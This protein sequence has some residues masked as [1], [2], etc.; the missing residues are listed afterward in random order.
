MS[1]PRF[2]FVDEDVEGDRLYLKGEE[3]H[4]AVR[5]A[6]VRV[7]ERIEAINGR[8]RCLKGR[9]VEIK[10][11]YVA[12]A[13]EEERFEE[14]PGVKICLGFGLL[15]GDKNEQVIQ[16]GTELGVWKFLVFEGKRSVARLK[17]EGRRLER[18]RRVAIEACK[19]S[20]RAWVPEIEI[21]GFEGIVERRGEGL[22]LILSHRAKAELK[23]VLKEKVGFDKVLA[24]VGPEGGFEDEEIEYAQ[25]R[26][27]IPVSI[28]EKILRAE[29]AAIAI[30][31]I[32]A[33]ELVA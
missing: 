1:V 10:K 32:L 15:K 29:T 23:K 27:F 17:D 5:V 13:L 20:G 16:K 12:A 22:G 2:F 9:V 6:R 18:F 8:G 4:H 3:A 28:G 19:Q 24:I 30:C 21:V 26:G 31:A 7:G 25:G 11:G 14:E 33:Y